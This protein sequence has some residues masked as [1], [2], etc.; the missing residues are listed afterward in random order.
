MNCRQSDL[1]GFF[2][3][4]FRPS[5]HREK[6]SEDNI[7]ISG[8]DYLFDEYLSAENSGRNDEDCNILYQYCHKSPL[9][10]IT[11]IAFDDNDLSNIYS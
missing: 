10:E 8:D 2:F 1:H 9:D 7:N 5:E 6:N 11:H 3:I 4:F